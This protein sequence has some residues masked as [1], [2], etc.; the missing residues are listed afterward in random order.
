M[1]KDRLKRCAFCGRSEHEVGLLLTGLNG[2]ICD[3]C[4]EQAHTIV[5]D[6]RNATRGAARYNPGKLPT[7]HEIK[8]YLDQY[9]I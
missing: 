6:N 9:V 7:P 2:Y 3:E 8:D 1:T 5:Q 4:V